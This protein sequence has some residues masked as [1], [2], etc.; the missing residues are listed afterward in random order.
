MATKDPDVSDH[1]S[2]VQKAL[3]RRQGVSFIDRL[4][5]FDPRVLNV[6]YIAYHIGVISYFLTTVSFIYT[7]NNFC[8][9]Y[10]MLNTLVPGCV[11]DLCINFYHADVQGKPM[12]FGRQYSGC[13]CKAYKMNDH[14]GHPLVICL[15]SK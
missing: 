7:F 4:S 2:Q 3:E 5:L 6:R 12:E 11:P 15:P 13:T 10:F 1:G 8:I 14:N 9:F